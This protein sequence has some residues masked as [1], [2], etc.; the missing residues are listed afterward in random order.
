MIGRMIFIC[1]YFDQILT[2]ANAIDRM[3][4]IACEN[5]PLIFLAALFFSFQQEFFTSGNTWDKA[6]NVKNRTK[7]HRITSCMWDTG[8]STKSVID[9]GTWSII[10]HSTILIFQISNLFHYVAE[11]WGNIPFKGTRHGDAVAYVIVATLIRLFS[12]MT[13]CGLNTYC[14]VT[15][16]M[17]GFRLWIF[18]TKLESPKGDS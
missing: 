11:S 9:H 18:I 10:G 17:N 13:S 14:D 6:S 15:Q 12:I 5:K 8:C 1:F 16:C 7:K 4:V 3:H 2:Y